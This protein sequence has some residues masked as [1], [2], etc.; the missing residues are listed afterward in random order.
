[1]ISLIARVWPMTFVEGVC[2]DQLTGTRVSVYI[3]RDSKIVLAT[4][5][6]SLIRVDAPVEFYLSHGVTI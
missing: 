1:M 4:S 3:Q 5:K 6:R 2:V